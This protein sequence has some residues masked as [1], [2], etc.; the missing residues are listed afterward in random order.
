MVRNMGP[1]VVPGFAVAVNVSGVELVELVTCT[2]CDAGVPPP[3]WAL[4]VNEVGETSR[5]G[6]TLTSRLTGIVVLGFIAPGA[7][8]WMVP[9]QFVVVEGKTDVLID[10][11][12][13]VPVVPLVAVC[14]VGCTT[15]QFPQ[16][17]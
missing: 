5:S 16:F 4:Y 1:L 11:V 15:S 14:C 2:V 3:G 17:V 13:N 8:T 9:E 7:L 10:A 6:L 12:I